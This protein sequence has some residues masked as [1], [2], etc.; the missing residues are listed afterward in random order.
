MIP[1]KHYF[2]IIVVIYLISSLF[3]T[4]ISGTKIRTICIVYDLLYYYI[5]HS[6][7]NIVLKA[8]IS[9]HIFQ[10]GDLDTEVKSNTVLQTLKYYSLSLMI[11]NNGT[12]QIFD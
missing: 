5:Q 7:H 8:M 4:N 3:L 10:S 6:R 2:F 9:Y 11:L 1:I 12:R